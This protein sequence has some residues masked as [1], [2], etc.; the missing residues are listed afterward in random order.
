[1]LTIRFWEIYDYSNREEITKWLHEYVS[2]GWWRR[3][4]LHIA[5]IMARACGILGIVLIVVNFLG[6][7]LSGN[8]I[9]DGLFVGT[10]FSV[11]TIVV[12]VI[13]LI[14]YI[15]IKF[16]EAAFVRY[17]S[18]NVA[19]TSAIILKRAIKA[20]IDLG[21]MLMFALYMPVLYTFLQS[22]L[23]ECS[24]TIVD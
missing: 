5:I 23:C 24:F 21:I 20:K 16:T 7:G 2:D 14:G 17:V 6:E 19:Y 15:F 1:M 13:W 3:G 4:G 9:A 22:F 18:Q 10:I 11:G 12:L 8:P